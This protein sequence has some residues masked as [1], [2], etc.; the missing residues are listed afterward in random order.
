M[1]RKVFLILRDVLDS[2]TLQHLREELPTAQWQEGS[3]TTGAAARDRK[4]N[5]QVSPEEPRLESWQDTVEQALRSHP[6][7]QFLVVPKYFMPP[8]FNRYDETMF[9]RDHVDFPLLTKRGEP[10]MRADFSI[11]LFLSKPEEYSGG[12]LIIGFNDGDR[13]IKLQAGE[14][15]VYPASTLHRVETVHSGSRVAAITTIQSH[16]RGEERHAILQDLVYLWRRVE[17]IAPN[18]PEFRLAAKIHH[19]LIRLWAD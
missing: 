9:Y 12:E 6:M 11:T 18:S 2:E 4:R 17:D 10:R 19:N 13:R 7:M 16:I 3:A 14:A 5:L 1:G 8:V 15:I